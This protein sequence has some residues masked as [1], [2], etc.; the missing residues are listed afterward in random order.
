M[1]LSNLAE[2]FGINPEIMI[3]R[4]QE[5]SRCE[6][7]ENI[8]FINSRKDARVFVLHILRAYQK[9]YQTGRIRGYNIHEN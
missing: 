6:C 4:Y 8:E 5:P 3:L 2:K 9:G 1:S 7:G